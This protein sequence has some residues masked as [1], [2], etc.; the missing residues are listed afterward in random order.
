MGY[1]SYL[2]SKYMNSSL[3][4]S[5]T[6]CFTHTSAGLVTID[7]LTRSVSIYT[8]S[9]PTRLLFLQKQLATMSL[10]AF[11]IKQGVSCVHQLSSVQPTS[12]IHTVAS[13]M[14]V[15]AKLHQFWKTWATLGASP[16][17]IRILKEGYT[18]T[19]WNRPL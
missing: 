15:G 16:K 9:T 7:Q 6:D 3:I 13:T 2:L 4:T 17:V 18:L 10:P 8:R 1:S 11:S 12:N 14:H 5:S 19:F